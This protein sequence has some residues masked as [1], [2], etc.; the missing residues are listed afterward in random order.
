[1]YTPTTGRKEVIT[2]FYIYML[3]T[4]C[5]LVIDAGVVPPRSDPFPY[6]VAAQNGLA[7]AL[8]T[9]LLVNGFV[10]FQL[11]E[12]GTAL[13]VWLLRLTSAVMF[14][15]SFLISLL[16]FKSWG[17]LSPTNTVGMFVILY[18]VNAICIAVYLVMQLLL[19][20]NT[21]EDR[22]PLGH[23][24]FGVLVFICGQVLLYG[25]SDTICDNVQH[26]L[27]GL[28]FATFCNLLAV[29][30]VY[31]VSL[32]HLCLSYPMSVAPIMIADFPVS[33]SGITLPRRTWNSPSESS[34][35]PGKSRSFFRT[36]TVERQAT[37]TRIRSMPEAC[38]TT[39][40]RHIMAI[41]I[42]MDVIASFR[43]RQPSQFRFP[44]GSCP[45]PFPTDLALMPNE[46]SVH[47]RC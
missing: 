47:Y 32:C 5:S 13:S 19:V 37:K 29:M 45:S 34:L 17:G 46:I 7:S 27:D 16:T 25:F 21:L 41:I 26:Y 15:V 14:A 24:A 31:K 6:F 40:H 36:T 10:G 2:F 39:D 33:S 8:C 11:Y 42:N 43:V 44:N 12:D 23:I 20:M 4:M 30:M 38:I 9:C 35:T 1:M 3:L 22:W 28:V 18:I